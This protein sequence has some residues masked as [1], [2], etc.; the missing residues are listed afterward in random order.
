[1]FWSFGLWVIMWGTTLF[2][3]LSSRLM[4]L[5]LRRKNNRAAN[6][7]TDGSPIPSPAPR[8][9]FIPSLP[10]AE[11]TLGEGD[12]FSSKALD[13]TL[14]ASLSGETHDKFLGVS[15]AFNAATGAMVYPGTNADPPI[16]RLGLLAPLSSKKS[17]F[18]SWQQV[19]VFPPSEQHHWF[20]S[21]R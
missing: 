14:G 18:G 8:P 15:L 10:D 21:H 17:T 2:C 4:R 5:S 11:H 19:V 13:D 20:S 7:A 1:M 6:A 16:T 12:A 9:A 3:R